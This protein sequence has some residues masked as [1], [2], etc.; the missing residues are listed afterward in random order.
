MS[1]R[2]A[3]LADVTLGA[4]ARGVNATTRRRA[5]VIHHRAGRSSSRSNSAGHEGVRTAVHEHALGLRVNVLSDVQVD[6][7]R[8]RSCDAADSVPL[9][10]REGGAAKPAQ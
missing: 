7:L 8:R 9:G 2:L 1:D 4:R 6:G 10:T 3:P 5:G